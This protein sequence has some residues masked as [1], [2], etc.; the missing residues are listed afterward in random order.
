[1]SNRRDPAKCAEYYNEDFRIFDVDFSAEEV[2]L[3][4]GVTAGKRTC[5]DCFTDECQACAAALRYVLN[6]R[7]LIN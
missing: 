4:D 1:M 7:V 5:T 2:A 3:L 6:I